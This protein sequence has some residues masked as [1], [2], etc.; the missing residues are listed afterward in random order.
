MTVSL[1]PINIFVSW[2]ALR[3]RHRFFYRPQNLHK[4]NLAPIFFE[5][6]EA[7]KKSSVFSFKEE[8]NYQTRN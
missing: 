6:R 5:F 1:I 2:R 7:E 8:K 3:M 4:R